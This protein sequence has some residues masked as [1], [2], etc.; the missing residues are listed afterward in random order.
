MLNNQLYKGA[1]CLGCQCLWYKHPRMVDFKVSVSTAHTFLVAQ[2]S[3]PTG[4]YKWDL[5]TKG[6]K[7]MTG[8]WKGRKG[9]KERKEGEKKIKKKER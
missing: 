1:W 9:R 4:W 7:K 2:A 3:C 8:A 5:H 6:S